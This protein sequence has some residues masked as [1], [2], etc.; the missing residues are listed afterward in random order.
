MN[1]YITTIILS[2]ICGH[3]LAASEQEKVLR[4]QILDLG[5]QRIS[6]K[7]TPKEFCQQADPLFQRAEEAGLLKEPWMKPFIFYIKNDKCNLPAASA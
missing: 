6:D 1:K 3:A 7:V 5:V 2:L 4:D